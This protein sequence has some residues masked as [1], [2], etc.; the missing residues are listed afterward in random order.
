MPAATARKS[1]AS[2]AKGKKGFGLVRYFN[3]TIGELKKVVWLTRR[4][5]MYLTGLVIV[6]TIITGIILG[7]L[8]YGFTQLIGKVFIGG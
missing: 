6:V 2:A 5:I 1:A 8:D 7:G 4:E 3:E